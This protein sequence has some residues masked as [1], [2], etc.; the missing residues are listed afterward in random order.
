MSIGVYAFQFAYYPVI[1]LMVLLL[2][3]VMFFNV[4]LAVSFARSVNQL[5]EY[6]QDEFKKKSVYLNLAGK[7]LMPIIIPT[8]LIV[9][10][11]ISPQD[12]PNQATTFPSIYIPIAG[13]ILLLM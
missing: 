7:L 9:L 13:I 10:Y 6:S 4:F 12:D 1:L 8:I 3:Y 5:K 2:I 11:V